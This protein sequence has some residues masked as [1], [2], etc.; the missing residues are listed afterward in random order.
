MFPHNNITSREKNFHKNYLH[1]NPVRA[2][3]PFSKTNVMSSLYDH[4]QS[5]H[6]VHT[7]C[8]QTALASGKVALFWFHSSVCDHIFATLQ[9]L[10]QHK[11]KRKERTAID[12]NVRD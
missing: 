6:T 11:P 12:D 3:F 2:I 1:C 8:A 4:A 5:W 7:N 10:S 9:Q